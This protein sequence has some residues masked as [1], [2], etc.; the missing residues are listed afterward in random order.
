MKTVMAANDVH[1]KPELRRLIDFFNEKI[2]FYFESQGFIVNQFEIMQ[3]WANKS[4]SKMD[5]HA[6]RHPNSIV[7]GVFYFNNGDGDT[8]F[9]REVLE[10]DVI[11][12]STG[13]LTPFNSKTFR[14]RP[15]FGKLILFPSHLQHRVL[16]HQS[17]S[18]DRI[19]I[20][21]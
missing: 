21:F 13:Q 11:R 16:V 2:N 6:H 8:E 1:L 19:T 10:A 18:E 4:K 20:A 17:E 14:I 3:C 9:Y 12:P 5:H 15:Q 7:S